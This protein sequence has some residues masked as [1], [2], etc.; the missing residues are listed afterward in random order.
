LDAQIRTPVPLEAVSKRWM[1][2]VAHRLPPLI[3]AIRERRR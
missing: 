1:G 2:K 3:H